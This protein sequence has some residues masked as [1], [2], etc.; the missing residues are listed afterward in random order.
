[1]KIEEAK[2]KWCPMARSSW[3]HSNIPSTNYPTTTNN[4]VFI[5]NMPSTI[6]AAAVN[7]SGGVAA[8]DC[9]CLANGCMMW[10]TVLNDPADGHCG[11]AGFSPH[12]G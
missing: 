2:Q 5:E 9:R 1:M 3:I 10:R 6:A 11:L 4:K 8:S 7:R 12:G